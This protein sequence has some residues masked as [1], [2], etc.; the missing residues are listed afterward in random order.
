VDAGDLKEKG[1]IDGSIPMRQDKEEGRSV[2]R[3][4]MAER[5]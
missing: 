2:N 3:F 4:K 5:I 1:W